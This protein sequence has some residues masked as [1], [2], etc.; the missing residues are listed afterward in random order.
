MT[1]HEPMMTD[2]QIDRLLDV[3]LTALGG[4]DNAADLRRSWTALNGDERVVL[5]R[6]LLDLDAIPGRYLR[7]VPS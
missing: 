6:T 1:E 7:E 4:G 3:F 2:K 5:M